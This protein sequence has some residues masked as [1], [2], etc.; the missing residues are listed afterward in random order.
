VFHVRGLLRSIL[1]DVITQTA[2]QTFRSSRFVV[3]VA[4]SACG[5]WLATASYDKQIT[6]YDVESEMVADNDVLD[7][8]DD[9]YL[10]CEPSLRYKECRRIKVDHNPEAILFYSNWLVYT[11][12]SSHNMYY[13][14]VHTGETRTKSFNHHPLDTHISFS[15]L[16][17]VLHPGGKVI[18]FQ[19]GDHASGGERI[20]LYGAEPDQTERAGCI[21]TGNEGDDYVLP[22][23]AF[24][25]DGTGLM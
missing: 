12:R 10:A 17:M 25:P 11:T 23:M 7:D 24:L 3:R 5:K 4:F 9:P 19:T 6:I 8:T 22:R 14:N 1:T 16:N 18:A 20:L 21:W 15:V 2:L 13:V